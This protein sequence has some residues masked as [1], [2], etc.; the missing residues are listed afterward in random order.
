MK[1]KGSQNDNSKKKSNLS[2][3]VSHADATATIGGEDGWI[4]VLGN[5]KKAPSVPQQTS[6]KPQNSAALDS[7][8]QN[9]LFLPKALETKLHVHLQSKKKKCTTSLPP[10]KSASRHD[11][12]KPSF[13][14]I[15]MNGA[16]EN[17]SM[18]VNESELEQR[19]QSRGP[20]RV[21]RRFANENKRN[22]MKPTA[23]SLPKKWLVHSL[24]Q[25]Q[26]AVEEKSRAMNDSSLEKTQGFSATA[27]YLLELPADVLSRGVLSY[28]GP[29]DLLSLGSCSIHS[30]KLAGDGYL[31]KSIVARDFPNS[32]ILPVCDREW[33]MV[34]RLVSTNLVE[35]MRCF[36]TK[37][38][39]LEDIIG[40]G[41]D[42][43]M[44]PKTKR[45]DYI[46]VSQD[47][48][49][50]TAF[51]KQGHRRDVFGNEYK[52]FLPIYFTN[53]H[54]KRA[55]PTIRKTLA[56]LCPE[57]KSTVFC[58]DM[59]LDVLPKIV[60][61]FGLLLNDEAISAS[62][63][64]FEGF[65]RIHRLFLALSEEYPSI[66][67]EAVRRLNLFINRED[68]RTK[69]KLPNLG[70]ILPL[71]MVVNPNE[72]SWAKIRAT[73]LQETF[74]RC[75][76]WVCKKHPHLE[77]T[78]EDKK[79]AGVIE[80][81]DRGH[82]RVT[83]TR[84]AMDVPLRLIMFHVSFLRT[85]CWSSVAERSLGY[86]TYF[87]KPVLPP[88]CNAPSADG[89]EVLLDGDEGIAPTASVQVQ[90][91]SGALS[92]ERF[93]SQVEIIHN[94]KTWQKF[95]NFVGSAGPRSKDDMAKLLRF[96]V[97]NSRRKKY[98]KAGMDFS[99]VHASGSSKLLARGQEYNTTDG[100]RRVVFEDHWKFQGAT[101]FLDATCI[102]YSGKKMVKTID[103]N[104]TSGFGG[105]VQHSG[106]VMEAQSGTHTINI[107]LEA[108][109]ASITTL[110][111]VL[112]AWA[113]ATLADIIQPTIKFRN[114]DAD[115]ST[116]P[117]C[118]YDLDSHDKISHLTSV[119]MCKLYRSSRAG[120]W[121]VLAV[122][123]SHRGAADNYGP[124]YKAVQ[125]IL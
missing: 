112:S 106:D 125:G 49:S 28:L 61:T 3:Q 10:I 29:N 57:R 52:L 71:L 79:G 96:H 104:N 6:K 70:Q 17:N 30:S 32:G 110:V 13:L 44:N 9:S 103:Y 23:A 64:S 33:Q 67:D 91:P 46:A 50:S 77:R 92:F 7:L 14:S 65:T 100:L 51:Q 15:M 66:K 109:P 12:V 26:K 97:I 87:F 45:V 90:A 5:K 95:F 102:F 101:K 117:L 2:H 63:K 111:F 107:D 98:H 88:S 84:K 20:L 55:L 81:V 83:L 40:V 82:E 21:K 54:F 60:T 11:T 73:Y 122:G 120:R 113:Q 39:F 8:E 74:D 53:G 118:V 121:H 35:R 4:V 36:H 93:R 43:T 72:C 119:I 25:K 86:D 37:K 108:V 123:D 18:K 41:V 68:C 42:F 58:P 89:N 48:T 69:N 115:P 31:W 34:Y 75:V 27:E 124:I 78:T 62:Q 47:L 85:T 105:A 114:A 56:R 116:D 16:T 38:T 19:R 80:S 94:V 22:I 99:R 1:T 59:V 76:L 24:P